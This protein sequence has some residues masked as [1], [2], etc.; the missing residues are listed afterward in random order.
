M[1]QIITI[2]L[3][4]SMADT[5]NQAVKTKSYVNKS[6]F[7]RYL[8]RD[9]SEKELTNQ[10]LESNQQMKRGEKTLLKSFKGIRNM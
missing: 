6:E 7:F 9:W 10:T 5:V 2:S 4:K 3:P 1:R 8:I